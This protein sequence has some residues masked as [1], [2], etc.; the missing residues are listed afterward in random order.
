[1]V[2]LLVVGAWI[3]VG[4][5]VGVFQARRGHWSKSW[6]IGVVLGPL[7][8]P[9]AIATHRRE[10]ATGPRTVVAGDARD[11]GVDVLVGVDGSPCALRAASTV[12][13][14]FGDRL[15]RLTLATVLDF[16]TA[17]P[18]ADSVMQPAPW[19]EEI[20][21]DAT[22]RSAVAEIDDR[23]GFRPRAV[24]LAGRPADALQ[25]YALEHGFDLLAVGCR[26]GGLSTSLL[27]SCAS[28]LAEASRM[29]VLLI[30]H[31]ALSA[32]PATARSDLDG[33]C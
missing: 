24:V 15:G 33:A 21:A 31:P 29:P 10:I 22:L 5:A 13:A 16:D 2:V 6:V 11:E 4:V 32:A 18:H 20:D 9:F 1:V 23:L 3:A 14:T 19:P 27:G 8:V 30:P 12:A 28:S 17:T 7:L 26:G 25:T